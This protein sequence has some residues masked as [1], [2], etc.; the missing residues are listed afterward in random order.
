MGITAASVIAFAKTQ[1]GVKEIPANSNNVCYNTWYYGKPVS[2]AS[3]PW[4]CVFIAWLFQLDQKLC[5][6]TASCATLLDW[7]EK[8]KQIVKEPQPG[9]IVF[10]KYSTNKRRTNHVGLVVEVLGNGKIKTIE[11]NTSGK[12]DD[13]GGCVMERVRTGNIVAYARPKYSK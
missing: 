2:G 8:N 13:N 4:C 1:L 9:D 11:G 12:S 3:Y 5:L 10:F 7:F 6:K